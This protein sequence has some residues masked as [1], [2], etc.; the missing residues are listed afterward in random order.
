MAGSGSIWSRN[1][2][3]GT[4]T[5]DDLEVDSG[6]LS[7]DETNNRVGVGVTDPAS[8]LEVY[9]GA[10]VTS[11][12]LVDQDYSTTTA[13]TTTGMDIDIDKTGTSTSNNALY[14]INIDMDNTTATNGTNTMTG[15]KVTPTLTHAADA[16]T[17]VV[18]G[19]EVVATGGS[20]GGS[21]ARALDLIATG[22][23]YNQGIY[24]KI[25]DGG[26]DIKMVS[27]ADVGDYC[28]IAVGAAGA[29]T[30]TT[31]DDGGA[32]AH[33]TL[34]PDGDVIV[35]GATPKLTIGDGDT[36][37]TMLAFDG[38]AV[39]FRMGIDDGTDTLEIGKGTAHGTTPSIKIDSAT[40]LQLMHNSAVADTEYSGDLAMF[41]AGEALT[42]GEVVYFK[43]SDSRMWKAVATASATSRCV[44]MAMETTGAGSVG[45][46]LL[47][48]FARFDSEFPTYTIGGVLYT[49]EAETGGKNVPEQAAPDT[50]GDFVQ[51]IGWAVS[52]DAVYFCPDSTVIEVA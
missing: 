29:T 10:A 9:C 44:A 47:K 17:T 52:G 30:I 4:I 48:G 5:A 3:S 7:I 11:G 15:V 6:T 20:P 42:A 34:A 25:A 39:D 43:A 23:D 51:V 16:G 26:P 31:V 14:G 2:V 1:V 8:K 41:T 36:E 18:K 32:T 45:P 38:N 33:L 13:S 37:D 28:T 12:I 19:V 21:T 50:D 46:F 49:P 27:S 35:G 22:A 24:M 40:N